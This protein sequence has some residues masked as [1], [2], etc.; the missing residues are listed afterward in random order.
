MSLKESIAAGHKIIH[1]ANLH[2][3]AEI[4]GCKFSDASATLQRNM[5]AATT[6]K[7]ETLMR[8]QR[9]IM[10]L[11]NSNNQIVEGELGAAA[12]IEQE[13]IAEAALWRR[14]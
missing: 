13:Q 7:P 9:A 1:D 8:R 2:N 6:I 4:I 11:R 10:I 12:A 3:L 5:A 14:A